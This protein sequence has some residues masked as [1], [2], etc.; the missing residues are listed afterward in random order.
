MKVMNGMDGKEMV[1]IPGGEAEVGSLS[2][3]MEEQPVLAVEIEGFYMDRTLVTNAE[4]KVYC[5]AVGKDYPQSPSWEGYP[6]YFNNFPDYPVVNISWYDAAAYAKWAGKRLPT[7]KEWEYAAKGGGMSNIYPWGDAVVDG[8]KANYADRNT[9]YPWGDKLTSD[10]YRYTSPVGSFEANAYGLFDMSGNVWEWCDD[11]FHSYDTSEVSQAVLND[12]WGG[13]RVCRGGCYHSTAFDLRLARR[14]QVLGGGPQNGVGF[15]CV[16]D[17]EVRENETDADSTDERF[18]HELVVERE[19]NEVKLTLGMG[20]INADEARR[21]KQAG[22]DRVEQYVTWASVQPDHEDRWDFTKWDEQTKILE[23]A[24]LKW[25]PFLILGPAYSLPKWFRDSKAFTGLVCLEHNI[26]S[27]IQSIWD[28]DIDAYVEKFLGKVAEHY[29]DSDVIGA[30]ILGV[31]GDFGESIFPVWH[32]NWPTQIAGLYHSHEGYWCNDPFARKDFVESMKGSYKTIDALNEVWQTTY[33]DFEEVKLPE[34][35]L[36][37]VEGF[38]VDEYTRAGRFTP[39][40]AGDR[41]MWLDFV[42]WYRG[43]M[44]DYSDFWLKSARQYFGDTEVFLCTGGDATAPHGSNFAQQCKIAGQNGCGVRITNE[45][46]NYAMNFVITNWVA[47]AGKFYEA[48][49][50]FEP[51]GQVTNK[52]ILSRIYNGAAVGADE[53]HFYTANIFT[54]AKKEETFKDSVKFLGNNAVKRQVATLY[55]DTSIVLGDLKNGTFRGV[56]EQLREYTDYCFVDDLTIADGILDDFKILFLCI[57]GYYREKTLE[58]VKTWVEAGGLL[59]GYNLDRVDAVES[60][61]CYMNG[62]FECNEGVRQ[63]GSGYSLY[64]DEKVEPVKEEDQGIVGTS[65]EFMVYK[66]SSEYYQ[67]HIFD[68]ISVFLAERHHGVP[69][70]YLNG[71]YAS[72]VDDQVLLLNVLEEDVMTDVTNEKGNITNAVICNNSIAKV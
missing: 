66:E 43:S 40:N 34:L 2:G 49:F 32:G 26:E 56:F 53:V 8:K 22:F 36:D 24:G 48:Y 19:S 28:R 21:I 67:K 4:F 62:L 5:N 59:I 14:R 30:V 64:L 3:Y 13:S 71:I 55:P 68:K 12:G 9:D 42:D 6:D 60:D 52:G 51:A 7:E 69:N 10:G 63:L 27:K 16:S 25:M 72:L 57:G 31:T 38:R 11:W 39:K 61:V 20:M 35:E 44:T 70:G 65:A 54:E 23:E 29:E 37:P 47:S 58:A 46:S 33:N 1:F 18:Q 41:R 45:A 50:G 15:R 17:V